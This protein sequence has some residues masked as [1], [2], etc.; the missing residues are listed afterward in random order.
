MAKEDIDALVAYTKKQKNTPK[1]IKYD[2]GKS[3]G[4]YTR[5]NILLGKERF[6]TSLNVSWFKRLVMHLFF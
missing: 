1:R 6:I 2:S 4:L 3:A 5:G